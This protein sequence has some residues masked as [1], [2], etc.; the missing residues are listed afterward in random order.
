MLLGHEITKADANDGRVRHAQPVSPPPHAGP[1][2]GSR[3]VRRARREGVIWGARLDTGAAVLDCIVLD[4]SARGARL[5][6]GAPVAVPERVT[7]HLRDGRRFEAR[8]CW[9]HGTLAGLEF[10]APGA[11]LQA[12]EAIARR[13][14][15][16]LEALHRAGPAAWLP[17]LREE[18]F[19]GD[20]ALRQAAEAAEI[21]H[22]HLAKALGPHAG[23]GA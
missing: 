2:G 10:L 15:A 23:A 8:R 19:F 22:A 11:A 20:D 1:S 16:A 5:R 17:M 3:E 6:F 9:S 7:L 13:A 21:A 4:I 18:R 14:R 12:D